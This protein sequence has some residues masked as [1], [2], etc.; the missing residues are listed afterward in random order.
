MSIEKFTVSRDDEFHEGWPD[1]ALTESGKL[2]C[3]FTECVAHGN[4][5]MSRLM[6]TESSDRGRTWTKKRPLTER[7]TKEEYFNC[8]RI[9]TIPDGRL[10]IIC[11]KSYGSESPENKT[12]VY[13]WFSDD[14]GKTW[15]EPFLVP[16]HGYVPD[17]YRVLSSGRHIISIH[18]FG[19]SGKREQYLWYSDDGGK[20]W[21][22][23]IT[24]ASDER[25]DLCEGCIL[26]TKS[27]A[28]VC[29][30]RENSG[31]GIDCLK[32][33]SYDGGQTW[34][35][36]YNV[37][38]PACHR[39]VADYLGSGKIMLKHRFIQGGKGWLGN[40]TQNVFA[41]LLD[42]EQV[43]ETKRNAQSARIMPLDYDRSPVSDLGY[44]GWEQF[45]DGEIF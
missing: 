31:R 43:L 14:E 9:S 3:V 10:V 5:D 25:Y 36:V 32:T 23:Q 35:D 21:S 12:E 34:S 30:L 15:S 8:A 33:I 22:E 18:D 38:I 40:L 27:G 7:G 1:V 17:K 44:T 4:R 6:L 37:P 16:G 13:L 42:P 39:P 28:L 24:A 11:D 26:E 29:F 45:D 2:V 20:S 19:K 41:A